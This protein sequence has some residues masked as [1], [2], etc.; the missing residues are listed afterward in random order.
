L[1]RLLQGGINSCH[2]KREENL[3]PRLALDSSLWSGWQGRTRIWASLEVGGGVAGSRRSGVDRLFARSRPKGIEN[4][5]V[6][7]EVNEMGGSVGVDGVH[8]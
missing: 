4:E 8:T 2:S 7:L 3:A 6:N 5:V 1:F